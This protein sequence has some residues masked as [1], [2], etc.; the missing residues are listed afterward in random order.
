ML[1]GQ[2]WLGNAAE[3]NNL[4]RYSYHSLGKE[5]CFSIVLDEVA[6]HFLQGPLAVNC[7]ICTAAERCFSIVLDEVY[8]YFC[9]NYFLTTVLFALLQKGA[10][11]VY[12]MGS[13]ISVLK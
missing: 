1:D 10:R 6:P 7:A 3:K 9:K 11:C 12:E 5:R 13:V 4:V 2:L 8:I